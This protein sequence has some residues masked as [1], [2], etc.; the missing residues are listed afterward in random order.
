MTDQIRWGILSTANIGRKKVIPGIERATNSI[1]AAVASR[2]RD[3]AAAFAADLGIPRAYGSYEELLQDPDID[4]IYN[5]LPN[6]HHAEWA[7]KSAEAG[8]PMLCEKPLA[9][10]AAEAQ[11]MVDAFAAKGILFAEA[12]MY[13]FHP[14]HQ[15]VKHLI[16]SGAIGEMNTIQAT[17]SFD[18]SGREDD[19]RLKSDLAGGALMDIGCYC[20][21]VMRFITDEE[22]Q[23]VQAMAR[24]GKEVD[25]I[26]TGL[27]AFPSGVLGHFD[28]GFRAIVTNT[29]EVRGPK[30][31]IVVDTAFTPDWQ[32]EATIHHYHDQ[33]HTVITV[34]AA[35]QYQLMVEDFADALIRNRPP[36]FSPQDAVQNMAVIDQ[37][38]ASLKS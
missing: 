32:Q 26:L 37:L 35:D 14:Q 30:G 7:I 25:E 23:D 22:P 28:C 12:F 20:V 9:S 1:V 18:I 2:D 16:D 10:D 8:K 11:T 6:S 36:R 38:Y 5:P 19:I 3:R 13:R 27:L 33:G 21:N 29:Y 15:Q 31:R 17:F 24:M 34:P 4:A